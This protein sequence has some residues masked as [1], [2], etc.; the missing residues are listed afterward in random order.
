MNSIIESIWKLNSH[1]ASFAGGL[2]AL[3]ASLPCYHDCF[4][5]SWQFPYHSMTFGGSSPHAIYPG[6][7]PSCPWT[8]IVMGSGPSASTGNSEGVYVHMTM[9]CAAFDILQGESTLP[10]QLM[11]GARVITQEG[12]N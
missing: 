5:T 1:N 3:V 12:T 6:L 9:P 4:V 10:S 7:F 8:A 2:P 11:E